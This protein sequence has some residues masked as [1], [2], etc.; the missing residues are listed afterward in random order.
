VIA[1]TGDDEDNL[2]ICQVAKRRF[3]APRTIA[4]INNPK[5]EAIF[6]KLGIDTTISPTKLVLAAITADI[7]DQGVI[8]L[9]TLQQYGLDLIEL[10]LRATSPSVGRRPIDL[11]LPAGA[12]MLAVLRGGETLLYDR[13][14]TLE[15]GD[16]IL[17]TARLDDA[18][19]LRHAVV[20]QPVGT[21]LGA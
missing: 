7:P 12:R 6:I 9:A 5:N 13:T 21:F 2:V 10:T 11:S 16:V 17:A 1:V 14:M 15:S 8:H 19:A 3:K 4:R 18:D 20:G